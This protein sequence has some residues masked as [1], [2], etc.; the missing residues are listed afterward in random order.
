MW[1]KRACPHVSDGA[2]ATASVSR[3]FSLRQ[4]RGL[5]C[6]YGIGVVAVLRRTG[7]VRLNPVQA[8]LLNFCQA[9]VFK[10]GKVYLLAWFVLYIKISPTV[11]KGGALV[12]RLLA[13]YDLH[14]VSTTGASINLI[15]NTM[16]D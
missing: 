3:P 13:L 7:R 14:G 12:R 9:E 2:Q 5:E 15:T 4:L 8:Q 1:A 16:V 6:L 10:F 11:M